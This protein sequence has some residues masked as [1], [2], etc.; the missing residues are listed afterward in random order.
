M[1][2]LNKIILLIAKIRMA[3]TALKSNEEDMRHSAPKFVA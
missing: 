2:L 3:K 1:F